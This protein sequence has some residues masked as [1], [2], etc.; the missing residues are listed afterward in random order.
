ML[1][2]ILCRYYDPFACLVFFDMLTLLRFGSGCGR[3]KGASWV[4]LNASLSFLEA[5]PDLSFRIFSERSGTCRG[6]FLLLL[7]FEFPQ[8]LCKDRFPEPLLLRKSGDQRRH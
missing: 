4:P 8:D 5:F 6:D 3:L 2:G 7:C 1:L